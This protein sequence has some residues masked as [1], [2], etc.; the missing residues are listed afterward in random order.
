MS[1]N[2]KEASVTGAGLGRREAEKNEAKLF[3]N[4]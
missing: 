3:R 4:L 2:S 1:D